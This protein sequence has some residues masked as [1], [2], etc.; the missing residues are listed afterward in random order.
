MCQRES[1]EKTKP[2]PFCGN[3]RVLINPERGIVWC[4]KALGG[5]EATIDTRGGSEAEAI[6]RWNK[7]A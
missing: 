6:E 5:C 4:P 7:R 1:P 3:A 2:C